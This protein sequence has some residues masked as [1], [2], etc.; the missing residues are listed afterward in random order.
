MRPWKESELFWIVK[1]GLKYTG[2]PGWIAPERDDEIWAVVA[3][4]KR[5]PTLNADSYRDLALGSVRV[6]E[7][8][9]SEL[10]TMESHPEA[11]SACA[12]CHGSEGQLPMSDLVPVLHGQP[13]DYLLSAIAGLCRWDAAERDHAATRGGPASRR[14]ASPG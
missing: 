10:A 13:V 14:H 2:M 11:F 12:R 5:L 9:G 6:S 3:F 1:H 8:T 4:L 7:R